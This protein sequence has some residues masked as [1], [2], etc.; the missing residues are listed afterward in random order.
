MEFL[1]KSRNQED[2]EIL[3]K[4]CFDTL[5]KKLNIKQDSNEFCGIYFENRLREINKIE[6]FSVVNSFVNCSEYN[7]PFFIFSPNS[8]SILELHKK[9][10]K[11]RIV[12]IKIPEGKSHDDYSR[13]MIKDIW[14]YLPKGFERLLF[15][16][17]DGFLIKSGWEKFVLDNKLDYIGSAWCHAPSIDIKFKNEWTNLNFPRIQCGNGGFSYR[18]RSCCER[19]SNEFSQ[20]VLRENGREDNRPPPEDLFYSHIMN[21]IRDGGR[22]ASV[23]QAM[24]FSLDPITLDEYN[25]KLSFGFHYPKKINEFQKHRDYYL[26]L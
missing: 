14:N 17:P 23:R 10:P 1:N 19:V 7:Y 12:H 15:F 3:G 13:F 24:K 2:L 11:S 20:F 5:S 6:D 16:H 8:N 26:S 21:G 9:Y 18:T 25:R 22:V 4:I